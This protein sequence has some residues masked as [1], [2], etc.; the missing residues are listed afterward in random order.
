MSQK[1]QGQGWIL[2]INMK[3]VKTLREIKVVQVIAS[4]K[5]SNFR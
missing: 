1:E 5:A 2:E 3:T 4:E